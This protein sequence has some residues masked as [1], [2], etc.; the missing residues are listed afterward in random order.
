MAYSLV[1]MDGINGNERRGVFFLVST[2]EGFVN[3]YQ[4][5]DGDKGGKVLRRRQLRTSA[6]YYVDGV[7]KNTHHHG[8]DKSQKKGQYTECYV[9]KTRPN[10]RF[11]GFLFHPQSKPRMEVS[12]IV[13]H[14]TKSQDDTDMSVLNKVLGV[15]CRPEIVGLVGT[16]EI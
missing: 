5:Q 2:E 3:A 16:L 6:Q 7:V 15:R 13:H 8:W 11:Y 14:T 10:H 4:A 1:A 12:V 9:F